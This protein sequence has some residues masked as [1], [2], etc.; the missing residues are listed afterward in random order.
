MTSTRWGVYNLQ[1]RDKNGNVVDG[2]AKTASSWFVRWRVDGQLRKRSFRAKG[3]AQ[4]FR[5]HL[6]R[7]K[8]M[9]W[10]ADSRGWPLDPTVVVAEPPA[11]PQRSSLSLRTYCE[12][13]W[14]PIMSPTF[15]DKNLIGHRHNMRT[16]LDLLVY[17]V[18]DVRTGGPGQPRAGDS[19]LLGDLVAD[20]LRRAVVER[21]S[22]NRR[23]AAANARLINDALD[24][25][26][27]AITVRPESASP[28]T[29]RA[30][31]ITLS[32]IVKAAMRSGHTTGDP[33]DGVA[34][35]A[36]ASRGAGL[37]SRVVPSI[38]EVFDL[39]DAIATLGPRLDGHHAG[40]RFRS[41]IL[42]AGTLGPRPGELVAHRP[43]WIIW[44]TPTV[45]QFH[46]T[47]AA[48]Y[49]RESGVRGNRTRELKH[50]R[51][52]EH[53]SVPAL[54]PVA[55]ALRTHL[56]R[57]YGS[58]DRVWTSPTGRGHLNWGNILDVYW[59]P[60]CHKVF[61]G[62]EKDAL[63]TMTP[64]TL[65]KAAITFW[66]DSGINPFLAAEWAGHSAEVSQRF[67]A[68]RASSSFA[69]EVDQLR[70]H[71]ERTR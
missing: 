13:V 31:Y 28:A 2:K 46:E 39:A 20:D 67:Y 25:G 59:R 35:L 45:L 32:M 14:W 55:D 42:V 26:S 36:P 69:S 47:E 8:L 10:P 37:T 9:G 21:R 71:R 70:S 34:T 64:K 33:L 63:T 19:I 57:G 54:D 24:R 60:A 68:G 30:F 65:R 11:P 43:E 62:T 51:P 4:T 49:D 58:D 41:L 3:H 23:T 5:D 6:L 50:R 40:E 17:P 44:G 15:G 52:G 29:V 53:R 22:M 38:D 7:A 48:V 61:A 27:D 66:L 18:G 16:A 56:E 12:T 1:A